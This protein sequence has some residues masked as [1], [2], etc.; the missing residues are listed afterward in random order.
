MIKYTKLLD[1]SRNN[2]VF[3]LNNILSDMFMKS[4]GLVKE[5]S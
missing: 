4:D 2:S 3:K 5:V 1:T